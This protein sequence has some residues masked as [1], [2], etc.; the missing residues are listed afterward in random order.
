MI[1]TRILL[2]PANT[3]EDAPVSV[4][5]ELREPYLTRLDV[6]FPDG[7]ALMVRARFMYGVKQLFPQPEGAWLVGNGETVSWDELLKFWELPIL[8]RCEA[9]SP[10]TSYQHQ[11]AIRLITKEEEAVPPWKAF[12]DFFARIMRIFT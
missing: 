6:H 10:G 12:R 4:E 2:V 1:Y 9:C 7:C 5:F 3:S 8:L 11:L